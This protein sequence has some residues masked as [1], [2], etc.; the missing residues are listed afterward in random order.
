MSD[1]LCSACG[2]VGEINTIDRM[3]LPCPTCMESD[4]AADTTR[5]R[6]AL[7]QAWKMADDRAPDIHA[8]R[9]FLA[10]AARL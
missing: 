1:E 8:I 2:G 6:T 10:K 9:A 3:V 7:M 4:Y 5:L